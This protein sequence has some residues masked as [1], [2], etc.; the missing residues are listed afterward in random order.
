MDLLLIIKILLTLHCWVKSIDFEDNSKNSCDCKY[1]FI[2]I[3]DK[4]SSNNISIRKRSENLN[5]DIML[6]VHY[7]TYLLNV[8]F[9]KISNITPMGKYMLNQW[10]M[11]TYL[12]EMSKALKDE[13][14]R[15]GD[16]INQRLRWG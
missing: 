11:L 4:N 8:S 3:G 9:Y 7:G 16:E 1:L 6:K 10:S 2:N 13:R 14:L 15:I 12:C 5:T